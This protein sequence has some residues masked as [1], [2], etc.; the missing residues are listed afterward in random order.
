MRIT[1]FSKPKQTNEPDLF[2]FQIFL[3]FVCFK[4]NPFDHF[5]CDDHH[6]EEFLGN[7]FIITFLGIFSQCLKCVCIFLNLFCG[8]ICNRKKT[9]KITELIENENWWY[10]R[11]NDKVVFR[12]VFLFFHL[13][14]IIFRVLK[15]S[16]V[17]NPLLQQKFSV[18]IFIFFL[19]LSFP[20]IMRQY[21]F[22]VVVGKEKLEIF[23]KNKKLEM[24][25]TFDL[26]TLSS[27]LHGVC[28]CYFTLKLDKVT[29]THDK[30]Q[31]N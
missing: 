22:V 18:K 20:I 24:M 3:T 28:A 17:K 16:T 8:V 6:H 31:S 26:P 29:Q 9:R 23:L 2:F 4:D 7:F 15:I 11:L 19:T 27:S 13:N 10:F 21:Y 5:F 25:M 30:L 12:F 14:A 1:I